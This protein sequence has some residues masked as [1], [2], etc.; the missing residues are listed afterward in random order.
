MSLD[1]SH[2]VFVSVCL[3]LINI[4][5]IPVV[6]A[7]TPCRKESFFAL[8]VLGEE[9]WWSITILVMIRA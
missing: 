5:C 2:L 4:A 7:L 8:A 1:D 6:M 3:V 9:G